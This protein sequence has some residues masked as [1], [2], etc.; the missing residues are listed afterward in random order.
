[1]RNDSLIASRK[2]DFRAVARLTVEAAS[3]NRLLAE[4]GD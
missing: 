2:S 3:I 4:C 1:L